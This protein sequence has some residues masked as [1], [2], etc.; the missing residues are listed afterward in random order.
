LTSTYWYQIYRDNQD[1]GVR[2]SWDGITYWDA[3][4]TTLSQDWASQTV[5][6]D[7][8]SFATNSTARAEWAYV[9]I[10]S[11][12]PSPVPEPASVTLMGLGILG[13]VAKR[14]RRQ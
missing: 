11:P 10:E 8:R 9:S 3:L 12:D 13:M 7:T 5:V 6:L 1:I 2:Y 4:S 14:F